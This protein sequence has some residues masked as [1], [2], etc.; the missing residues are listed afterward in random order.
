MSAAVP[1]ANPPD[2]DG[3]W[4]QLVPDEAGANTPYGQY[5]RDGDLIWAEFYAGGSL[6]SGRL[7]GHLQSDGS[8]EAAYCLLTAA[9]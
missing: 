9:R 7:V 1:E 5:H 4:F 3:V 6:R 2:V 8:I